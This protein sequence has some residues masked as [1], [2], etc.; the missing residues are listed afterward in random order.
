MK[1]F[2]I[3]RGSATEFYTSMLLSQRFV[4]S[5]CQENR[6]CFVMS[7]TSSGS[8]ALPT[9]PEPL[10]YH[11]NFTIVTLR[12]SVKYIF[13]LK[14][15]F[16]NNGIDND[17]QLFLLINILSINENPK[18]S[19]YLEIISNEFEDDYFS[20]SHVLI[21]SPVFEKKKVSNSF[22]IWSNSP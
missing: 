3:S 12:N 13:R 11:F 10:C 2:I 7:E 6:L 5:R 8:A 21:A 20:S 16:C 15:W 9:Y 14:C 1:F 22:K 19:I 17:R 4:T 18:C